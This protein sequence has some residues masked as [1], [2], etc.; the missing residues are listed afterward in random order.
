MKISLHPP[1]LSWRLVLF[2]TA[3]LALLLSGSSRAA[4]FDNSRYENTSNTVNSAFMAKDT[5]SFSAGYSPIDWSGYL[6]A[7]KLNAD[8]TF[9]P[10]VWDAGSKLDGVNFGD[11]VVFSAKFDADGS[12]GGGLEFSEFSHLDDKARSLLMRISAADEALDTGQTRMDWLRGSH[13]SELNGSMRKR[14]TILGSVV[15]SQPLY[16]SHPADGY[17]NTWPK[18]S[19]GR[20]SPES[21]AAS[22]PMAGTGYVSYEQ[23][24]INHRA[25][26]PVV[27]LAANDGMLHAFDASQNADG[28]VSANAGKELWAYVPRS[29]YANL[30]ALTRKVDVAFIPTVDATPVSRDVFF[31]SAT[32]TPAPSSAGWHTILVGGLGRGGRGV[33]ALDVT[34]PGSANGP[35][36]IN[37][38]NADRM[39]LWEFDAGM[40]RVSSGNEAAGSAPGGS[41]SDL[42]YTYGQPNIGRLGNGRWAVL[43]PSGVLP[44]CE[45]AG[46]SGGC[47]NDQVSASSSLFVVDAQ[48][49]RLVAELKTPGTLASAPSFALSSPVLGDY[50]DDQVDDVAFA[51]DGAGN[52]WRYDLSSSDPMQWSVKLAYRPETPGAQAITVMP[53]LLPDPVTNRFIVIF[54]TNSV[55]LKDDGPTSEAGAGAATQAVYGIRDL[56]HTVDGTRKL[57]KQTLTERVLP[58]AGNQT[59][60][61]GLTSLSVPP[62]S[63]GWYFN[64]IAPGERVTLSAAALFDT[65]RV[66]ITTRINCAPAC[67]AARRGAVMV[68]DAS[69]GGA[70]DGLSLASGA[71]VADSL[72][73]KPVGGYV[74]NPPLAGMLP[75]AAE[76]GGGKL[77]FPGM[78]LS[79][80]GAV[81][82]DDSVWRR[83]SWRE[84][85]N[86]F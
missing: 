51:G 65:N 15:R 5:L 69:T 2:V 60:V 59:P 58:G 56:G 6:V 50:N 84:L 38:A 34:Q 64:L 47:S 86:D 28:S 61:R 37:S 53:R 46:S 82:V 66:V 27:Y 76:I 1:V 63:D 85:P 49:G 13:T 4:G 35:S 83:R 41:P 12:F 42:G 39:V 75:V 16:V 45:K 81:S 10:L 70:G 48:T 7:N 43:I 57:I 11:R 9:G 23:F 77:V 44:Q 21:L 32:G 74:N 52:L 31:A 3:A 30:G 71:W 54:G 24:A 20:D 8:G 25:R 29:A 67:S 79:G 80:G 18:D 26:R 55:S 62:G 19:T 14:R 22:R 36:G 33:Y 73:F 17:R 78:T 68:V 40:P 72:T